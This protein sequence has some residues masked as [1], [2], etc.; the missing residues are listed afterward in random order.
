MFRNDTV[1][2]RFMNTLADVLHVGILW[3]LFSIPVI[4]AGAAAT[5][6][7]YTMAK[8]VRHQTGYISKE[9]WHSFKANFRQ[10]LPL[11]LLFLAAALVL[12]FDIVYVWQNT[13]SVND[14]LFVVFVLIA[15]FVCG[16]AAYAPPVL[17]RFDKRNG[18]LLK[19]AFVLMFRYLP[20]TI[21]ILFVFLVACVGIYLMPWAIL[22]IPGVYI[23]ALTFP[24]ERILRKLMPPVE[25]DSEEAQKWYYQ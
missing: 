20:V 3:V 9:F 10:M 13:G 22:V 15:F 24:M 23:Y 4:T 1:F 14:A 6:A 8:C 2:A 5:A 19:A 18:E 12:V 11:N 17:S 16:L 25:E 7:Y 21:G